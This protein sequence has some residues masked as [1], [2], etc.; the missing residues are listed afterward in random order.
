M[1][2]YYVDGWVLNIKKIFYQGTLEKYLKENDAAYVL[3]VL[4]SIMIGKYKN[5]VEVYCYIPQNSGY[6]RD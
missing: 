3:C 1:L 2:F 4:P 5:G 6:T